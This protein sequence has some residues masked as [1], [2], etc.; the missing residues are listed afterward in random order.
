MVFLIGPLVVSL[1]S[2][3]ILSSA[4]LVEVKP[5]G[6]YFG[7]AP[8]SQ[9]TLPKQTCTVELCHSNGI[10]KRCQTSEYQN[11]HSLIILDLK[12]CTYAVLVL[13]AVFYSKH[14]I[15]FLCASDAL[16]YF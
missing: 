13:G 9:K 12:L 14:S 15:H 16:F 5:Q 4:A 7:V 11:K 2:F 6:I 8:I 1:V 10:S 3:P